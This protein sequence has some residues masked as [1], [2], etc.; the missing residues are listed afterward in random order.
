MNTL[1]NKVILV[2]GASKGIGAGSSKKAVHIFHNR[3][4]VIT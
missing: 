3:T 4:K 1:Q 2:P